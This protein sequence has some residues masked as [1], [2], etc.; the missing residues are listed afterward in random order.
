MIQQVKKF[1]RLSAARK[2]IMVQAFILSLYTHVLFRFFKKSAHFGKAA[3]TNNVQQQPDAKASDIAYAIQAV[4]KLVPWNNVCRHQAY[5]AKILCNWN[6]LP[7]RIFVGFK[8]NKE[9]GEIQA[10]AWTVAGGKIITG[11]CNP[12]EYT[13]Q[14][15]Y[16]NEWQ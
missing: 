3:V 14:N 8:K 2:K 6:R 16:Q 1:T 15:I 4:G 5:Q 13:I 7:Y 12:G 9:N 10:H 11:F